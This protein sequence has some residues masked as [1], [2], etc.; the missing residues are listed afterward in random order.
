MDP[1]R[2]GMMS[3]LTSAVKAANI[4]G[5][6]MSAFESSMQSGA[7]PDAETQSMEMQI[8]GSTDT[9]TAKTGQLIRDMDYLITHLAFGVVFVAGK[10]NFGIQGIEDFRFVGEA[11]DDSRDSREHKTDAFDRETEE[12]KFPIRLGITEEF[13]IFA[14]EMLMNMIPGIG[15]LLGLF[16][17]ARDFV[18]GDTVL[19]RAI[20]LGMIIPDL[21]ALGPSQ[22]PLDASKQGMKTAADASDALGKSS[23]NLSKVPNNLGGFGNLLDSIVMKVNKYGG[24]GTK[25][26]KGVKKIIFAPF[27]LIKKIFGVF[28]PS[29]GADK[30]IKAVNSKK[31]SKFGADKLTTRELLD[32]NE[33]AKLYGDDFIKKATKEEIS[34]MEKFVLSSHMEDADK[35]FKQE[36]KT[37][38]EKGLDPD[39]AEALAE[40]KRLDYLKSNTELVHNLD[41]SKALNAAYEESLKDAMGRIIRDRADAVTDLQ[42]QAFDGIDPNNFDVLIE[43][44]KIAEDL[45]SAANVKADAVNEVTH[46]IW[47]TRFPKVSAV[48]SVSDIALIFKA[49]ITLLFKTPFKALK[50]LP[51]AI[52]KIGKG[53]SDWLG[54]FRKASDNAA[55]NNKA[56]SESLFEQTRKNLAEV[57]GEPL[58]Q[59]MKQADEIFLETQIVVNRAVRKA[60]SQYDAIIK[61]CPSSVKAHS[62]TGEIPVDHS[63]DLN[64]LDCGVVNLIFKN[65]DFTHAGL[66]TKFKAL[67]PDVQKNFPNVK[68]MISSDKP[69]EILFDGKAST[70]K[71]TLR[72]LHILSDTALKPTK[73]VAEQNAILTTFTKI[74]GSLDDPVNAKY[75]ESFR[76][77]DA[78]TWIPLKNDP[79]TGDLIFDTGSDT[80]KEVSKF[81]DVEQNSVFDELGLQKFMA[82]KNGEIVKNYGDDLASQMDQ[83]MDTSTGFGKKAKD[84]LN[85]D[86]EKN[87]EEAFDKNTGKFNRKGLDFSYVAEVEHALEDARMHRDIIAAHI[88]VSG[89]IP[90]DKAYSQADVFTKNILYKPTSPNGWDHVIAY[91]LPQ[92]EDG[93]WVMKGDD[94]IYGL[95]EV[96]STINSKSGLFRKSGRY[97]TQESGGAADVWIK[98]KRNPDIIEGVAE[99]QGLTKAEAASLQ[100]T[101]SNKM[102]DMMD[103]T[104]L[105]GSNSGLLLTEDLLTKTSRNNGDFSS[106]IA[107]IYK[108]PDG[109][110]KSHSID[111]VSFEELSY[112]SDSTPLPDQMLKRKYWDSSSGKFIWAQVEIYDGNGIPI[113][114]VGEF[115]ASFIGGSNPAATN[116][117]SPKDAFTF[118]DG[119][120][121]MRNDILL[122]ADTFHKLNLLLINENL[123]E[124]E[125]FNNPHLFTKE[126]ID[127]L[128]RQYNFEKAWTNKK[129]IKFKAYDVEGNLI[130]VEFPYRVQIVDVNTYPGLK[131]KTVHSNGE[132][133]T[134]SELAIAQRELRKQIAE[135]ESK[136]LSAITTNNDFVSGT[137]G[138]PD[139]VDDRYFALSHESISSRPID[140]MKS[141]LQPVGEKGTSKTWKFPVIDSNTGQTIDIQMDFDYP[142]NKNAAS[143]R[144]EQMMGNSFNENYERF[145]ATLIGPDASNDGIAAL[146]QTRGSVYQGSS[147]KLSIVAVE[148]KVGQ[149]VDISEVDEIFIVDGFPDDFYTR[150]VNRHRVSDGDAALAKLEESRSYLM[151]F[152][153]QKHDLPDDVAE[154]LTDLLAGESRYSKD[155]LNPKNP[156][157]LDWKGFEE[158]FDSKFTEKNMFRKHP[159]RASYGTDGVKTGDFTKTLRQLSDYF[160]DDLLESAGK[161]SA[162]RYLHMSSAIKNRFK[163]ILEPLLEGQVLLNSEISMNGVVNTAYREVFQPITSSDI[164]LMYDEYTELSLQMEQLISS[165]SSASI[166]DMIREVIKFDYLTM[167]TQL[168]DSIISESTRI[169]VDVLDIYGNLTEQIGYQYSISDT[170]LGQAVQFNIRLTQNLTSAWVMN[171]IYNTAIPIIIHGGWNPDLFV[172]ASFSG[173]LQ[174]EIDAGM[175]PRANFLDFNEKMNFLKLVMNYEIV[176]STILGMDSLGSLTNIFGLYAQNLDP[177]VLDMF[178]SKYKTILK[179]QLKSDSDYVIYD[180]NVKA[181]VSWVDFFDNLMDATMVDMFRSS[182]PK[183]NLDAG[184]IL[185]DIVLEEQIVLRPLEFSKSNTYIDILKSKS[186]MDTNIATITMQ[187]DATSISYNDFYFTFDADLNDHM[188]NSNIWEQVDPLGLSYVKSMDLAISP[189]AFDRFG[190]IETLL[191][192]AF[193]NSRVDMLYPAITLSNARE[194]VSSLETKYDSLGLISRNKG[195]VEAFFSTFDLS[196]SLDFFKFGVRNNYGELPIIVKFYLKI[197]VNPN[198]HYNN[199]GYSDYLLNKPYSTLFKS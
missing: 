191:H 85:A 69:G 164:G 117:L 182:N 115:K 114:T 155:A 84:K 93:T 197:L 137:F 95:G 187:S 161:S 119:E 144:L 128:S 172:D 156:T 170:Y 160:S 26:N 189:D 41:A 109:K 157:T 68:A 181:N 148:G 110:I 27:K 99:M 30:A 174:S 53:I 4:D 83:F 180:A 159:G 162:D 100:N 150:A 123:L 55:I 124:P 32:A 118:V 19:D 58:E 56:I 2:G 70:L 67:S 195:N 65:Y 63:M 18:F 112:L 40:V 12:N 154:W 120:W 141:H 152:F 173:D 13:W 43:K 165:R 107:Y 23:K 168:R 74:V 37:L 121:V 79:V 59:F 44:G 48:S 183:A 139:Y 169:S 6:D 125:F 5:V 126:A 25:L 54:G 167:Q 188:A 50:E 75:I 178:R 166:G 151:E 134:E 8:S 113:K 11:D 98:S 52:K 131:Y 89:G 9:T 66:K 143:A 145:G 42:K 106:P 193:G 38:I 153:T 81:I 17:D 61:A 194:F 31:V 57:G 16:Q 111:M 190:G 142:V 78:V 7:V 76:I 92:L 158:W 24:G 87:L 80:Y 47:G 147:H 138:Q 36:R 91:R 82:R 33:I 198:Y 14:V 136:Q 108:N 64:S 39:Q 140:I 90:I 104:S 73:T 35:V 192:N 179:H 122:E 46:S 96:R 177:S 135:I 10:E 176:D 105:Y 22:T 199:G 185:S 77:N 146:K 102:L 3:L 88:S 28:I 45:L 129:T 72:E 184:S 133:L 34:R 130:D 1:I 51:S 86:I 186:P 149:S 103:Q 127:D 101:L 132:P 116:F 20:G 196:F 21:L 29:R 94:W 97:G 49:W 15:D 60:D 171:G 71:K 62:L 175:L 163:S